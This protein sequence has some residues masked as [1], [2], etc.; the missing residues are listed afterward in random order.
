MIDALPSTIRGINALGEAEKIAIYQQL[1][2]DWVLMRFH[3]D[4][5]SLLR[6][7]REVVSFRC[8]AGSRAMEIQILAHPDDTDPL[9]Y[10]NMIDT[11]N[12]QL[13]VLLLVINDP[14]APRFNTD[15][16]AQ[17]KPTYFGTKTRNL[18]EEERAMLAGLAPGQIKMGLRAFKTTIPLF[19]NFVA[20]MGRP[21]FM[22]EPLSYHNAVVFERYGFAYTY[23]RRE[24][25]EINEG[26]QIGG[27]L[28][29]RLDGSTPF[30]QPHA[31]ETIRGRAWA[32]HDGILGYPF[33]GFQMYKRLGEHAEISTFP[34]GK[35]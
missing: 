14:D 15:Q 17:G 9:I 26:F 19:E 1:I 30:R 29:Q 28:H 8:P 23:G 27:F 21:L 22:I 32:I 25:E 3:I 34:N 16:D 20:R 6:E 24:M 5:V 18:P 2:P 33:T 4:P 12:N 13:M 10:L 31:A 7:G 11:F 35:W